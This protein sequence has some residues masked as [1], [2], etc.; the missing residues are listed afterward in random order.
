MENLL[1]LIKLS[2]IQTIFQH[3]SVISKRN[4]QGVTKLIEVLTYGYGMKSN[5]CIESIF[6]T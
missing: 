1:L 5:F 4:Y 2:I 3:F 6:F